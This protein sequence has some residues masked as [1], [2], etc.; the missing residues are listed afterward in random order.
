MDRGDA[1][2]LAAVVTPDLDC[3]I[4]LSLLTGLRPKPCLSS[5]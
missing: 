5:G 1:A 4:E 3:W 2:Q